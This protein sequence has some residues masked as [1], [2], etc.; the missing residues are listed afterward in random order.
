MTDPI[1]FFLDGNEV[2]A[3]PGETIWQVAD[4]AGI[5]RALAGFAGTACGL[6][7]GIASIKILSGPAFLRRQLVLNRS[8]AWGK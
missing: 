4:R 7:R 2:E 6:I 3:A 1:R 8:Y 5:V